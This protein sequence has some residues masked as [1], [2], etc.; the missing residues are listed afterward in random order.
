MFC[1]CKSNNKEESFSFL[2][3][4]SS[5]D[6]GKIKNVDYKYIPN[7]KNKLNKTIV[8]YGRN[9]IFI[10]QFEFE[11]NEKCYVKIGYIQNITNLLYIIGILLQNYAEEIKNLDQN[12]SLNFQFCRTNLDEFKITEIEEFL[13]AKLYDGDN[14]LNFKVHIFFDEKYDISPREDETYIQSDYNLYKLRNKSYISRNAKGFYNNL[15]CPPTDFIKDS[16]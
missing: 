8:V 13:Y 4:D 12:Y 1:L 14:M 7:L 3:T 5:I 16:C 10:T 6:F 9:F 15:S 2:N 11:N